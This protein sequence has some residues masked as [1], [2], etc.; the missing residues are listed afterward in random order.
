MNL[1]SL[2]LF[3]LNDFSDQNHVARVSRVFSIIVKHSKNSSDL[4]QGLLLKKLRGSEV[5]FYSCRALNMTLKLLYINTDLWLFLFSKL[6]YI[7]KTKASVYYLLW[8][9]I[10]W[11]GPLIHIGCH[12]PP[13]LAINIIQLA[14]NWVSKHLCVIRQHYFVTIHTKHAVCSNQ[15]I[16]RST[17]QRLHSVSSDFPRSVYF[18]DGYWVTCH[19]AD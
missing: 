16:T 5:T 9:L 13:T 17:Y 3:G 2:S 14:L 1:F 19:F 7:L 6:L 15:H 18:A 10:F 12:M 8:Y 11:A 4:S